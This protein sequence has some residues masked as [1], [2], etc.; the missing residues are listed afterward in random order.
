MNANNLIVEI[1]TPQKKRTFEEVISCSAPGV[2]GSFQV[3]FNHAPLLSQLG[4]GEIKIETGEGQFYF[5]TSGGFLEVLNNRVS[6]LL[7]TCESADEIDIQ[8]AESAAE[9]A[10]RRLKEREKDLDETRAE[11]ALA[12]A[13]NRLRVARKIS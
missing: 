2:K 7:E 11:V 5:A 8:R 4:I 6:L 3:L 9:R 1:T 13:L 12:R 10:R